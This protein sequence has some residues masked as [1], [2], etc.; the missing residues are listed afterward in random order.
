MKRFVIIPTVLLSILALA[1][2]AS[3]QGTA[4]PDASCAGG[5]TSQIRGELIDIFCFTPTPVPATPT[6]TPTD[7]AVPPTPTDTAVP[8]TATATD[9]PTVTMT[10]L[11]TVISTATATET[12]T[13]TVTPVPLPTD[14]ATATNTAVPP[15]STAT[16]TSTPEPATG[17]GVIGDSASDPYQPIGRGGPDS[18][19]WTEIVRD[20]RSVDFGPADVYI[21]ATSGE[22]TNDIDDQTAELRPYIEADQI[23]TVIVWIGTNDLYPLCN[24]HYST[25]AYNNLKSVMLTNL[26]NGIIDLMTDGMV[27]NDIY[28]VTQADRTQQQVCSNATQFRQMVN[29]LNTAVATMSSAYGFT[30]IDF[31]DALTELSSYIVNASG[32]IS[33]DGATV[34]NAACDL[35]TCQRVADGHPNTALNGL[36]ANALFVGELGV[37]RLS[38]NEIAQAAGLE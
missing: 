28:M 2:F 14:T 35:P 7:T 10:Y 13:P 17:I 23:A 24:T 33:I 26:E 19:A 31:T 34:Y 22:T 15:T 4:V 37:G 5:F 16:P 11:P 9:T 32:D 21:V 30:L 38:D 8:P 6:A 20:W 12:G 25:T 29:E 18:Y 27:A 1:M 36:I 3:A